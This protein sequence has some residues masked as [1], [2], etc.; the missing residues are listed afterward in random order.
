MNKK[1]IL[2]NI[3]KKYENLPYVFRNMFGHN[4]SK[5]VSWKL[6]AD[7]ATV[8]ENSEVYAA[9]QLRSKDMSDVPVMGLVNCCKDVA[10]VMQGPLCLKDDFSYNTLAYYKKC[11]PNALIILSTWKDEDIK[12][13]KRIEDLGVIV[14]CSEK[15]EKPGHLNINYQVGNTLPGI[16]RAKQLGAKYVCKTRTD[17]RI[18]HP[19]AMA[20]FCSLLEQYPVNNEDDWK[21]IQNQRLLLLSMPYGDM[22]FPYCLS[23]FLYFGDV[24]DMI[25]LFSIPSDVREKGAVSRGVSR[26]EISENNLAP[27]VQLLRSYISRM[28]GNEECS[29]RAYWEFVKNHVITINKNQIDLYWHKYVGRYS[30]NTIYGTY[31]IDDSQ[32]AL[33]CYNFDFINWLNLYTGKYEYKAKYEKYMDFVWEE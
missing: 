32:D 28:G 13:L 31:Y 27:E 15:P 14:I 6:T 26:R 19:N 29:I 3:L 33:H 5:L 17:Q 1:E 24:D 2:Y 21:L 9:F 30:N 16:V 10:I 23:D 25:N 20:F 22:F 12:A 18:Y 4:I 8:E 11:Y 7:C